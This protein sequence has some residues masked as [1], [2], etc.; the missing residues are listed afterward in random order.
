MLFCPF[1]LL[2]KLP[3]S[4]FCFVGELLSLCFICEVIFLSLSPT[5]I[6]L[7]YTK[8]FDRAPIKWPWCH[9]DKSVL[10]RTRGEDG[11]VLQ[12]REV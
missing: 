5:S 6:S 7:V 11:Y 2:D 3:P 9:L 8:L 4:T 10:W 12:C 1:S